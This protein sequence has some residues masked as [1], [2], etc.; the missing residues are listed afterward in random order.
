MIISLSFTTAQNE[1]S[2]SILEIRNQDLEGYSNL[3][4]IEE[5]V[6][7]RSEILCLGLTAY[8]VNGFLSL[9]YSICYLLVGY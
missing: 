6:S 3:L 1:A 8:K 2:I 5:L 9:Y 7:T 4:Q